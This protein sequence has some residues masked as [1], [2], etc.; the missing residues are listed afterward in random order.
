MLYRQGIQDLT[1]VHARNERIVMETRRSTRAAIGQS[2]ALTVEWMMMDA[3]EE[4]IDVVLNHNPS[5]PRY[6][7]N[8]VG[9]SLSNPSHVNP[10][11]TCSQ[12]QAVVGAWDHVIFESYETLILDVPADGTTLPAYYKWLNTRQMLSCKLDTHDQLWKKFPVAM[13]DASIIAFGD[14]NNKLFCV[15]T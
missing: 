1:A 15:R 2:C 3:I 10:N 12:V 9:H 13:A 11:Q 14:V 4:N 6:S 7:G 8:E 5:F